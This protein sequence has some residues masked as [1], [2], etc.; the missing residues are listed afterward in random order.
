MKT[1]FESF[2]FIDLLLYTKTVIFGN[3]YF[4][5]NQ[6]VNKKLAYMGKATHNNFRHKIMIAI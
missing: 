6:L 5:N 2:S 4:I 3:S 1:S